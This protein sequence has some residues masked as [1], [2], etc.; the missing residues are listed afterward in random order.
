VSKTGYEVT[1]GAQAMGSAI[2][3]ARRNALVL[4]L[5]IVV[6]NEDDN[7]QS[8]GMRPAETITSAQ[9]DDIAQLLADL[10]AALAKA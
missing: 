1:N 3:Y 4:A 7:A 2:M 10:E 5:D 6:T 9:A 8:A